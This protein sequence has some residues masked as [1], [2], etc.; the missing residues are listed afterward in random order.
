MD[1]YEYWTYNKS[2]EHYLVRLDAAG[3]VTGVCGPMGS[4]I[5]METWRRYDYDS[6]P[7]HTEWL[8]L[9]AA[10]FHDA[11]LAAAPHSKW[12]MPS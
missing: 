3:L 10:E 1:R 4:E 5:P 12:A 9:H 2:G 7:R 8:R 11:T 6:Q